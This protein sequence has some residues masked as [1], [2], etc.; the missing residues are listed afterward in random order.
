MI[1]KNSVTVLLADDDS[2]DR[3]LFREA[4]SELQLNVNLE[5]VRDGEE[6]MKYLS[7]STVVLP[8]ILFLDL[9]MPFKNGFACLEEIRSNKIMKDIVVVIYSTTLSQKEID[10]VFDKGANL[11]VKKP[12]SFTEL[13]N[14]LSQILTFDWKH[15]PAVPEK[16]KFVFS[17]GSY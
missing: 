11:F 10:D 7:T 12:D 3:F 17:T 5:M 9:N 13:K 8:D 6:L 16:E 14:I 2:D 4:I 15:Y 1:S